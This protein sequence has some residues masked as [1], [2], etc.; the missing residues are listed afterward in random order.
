MIMLKIC[1]YLFFPV[2]VLNGV[3]AVSSDN[4]FLVVIT[5]MTAIITVALGC[6]ITA[7]IKHL[8][9]HPPREIVLESTCEARIKGIMLLLEQ[10]KNEVTSLKE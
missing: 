7:F 5:G 2:G 1:G 9:D 6:F 8:S 4:A 3:L 10:I